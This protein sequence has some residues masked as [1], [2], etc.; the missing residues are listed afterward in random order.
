MQMLWEKTHENSANQIVALSLACTNP[1]S[2]QWNFLLITN[3]VFSI[4]G[5]WLITDQTSNGWI[6][7]R[8]KV[9]KSNALKKLS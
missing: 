3:N 8:T 6:E 4:L 5:K 2:I 7:N 9:V 1:N